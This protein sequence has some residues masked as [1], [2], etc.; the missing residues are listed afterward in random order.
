MKA[1][2][3]KQYGG[4]E[5]LEVVDLPE[6][7]TAPGEVLVRVRAATVNP[8]DAFTRQGYTQELAPGIALPV[9]PGWDLA[10][11][12]DGRRVAGLLQWFEGTGHGAQ[13]EVVA[14]PEASLAPVPDGVDDVTAAAVPLNGLTARQAL[15]LLALEPGQVVL[16]TGATGAVGGFAVQLAAQAGAHVLAVGSYGDEAWLDSLGAKEVLGRAAPEELVAQVRE[17]FSDGVDA[18]LDAAPTGGLIGAVRDGGGYVT[19]IDPAVPAPERGIA[20][21]KV[22]VQPDGAQL[23][24]LLRLVADGRLAVRVA[25]TLPLERAGEAQQATGLRGKLVLTLGD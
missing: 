7:Q 25:G 10:G 2:Q 6:P 13:A 17:R 3:I 4:P 22:N 24:Q 19:V 14:V 1:L 23:A 8:V 9:T 21:V 15:D 12:A 20:P 18:V 16:V 11:T 5:V